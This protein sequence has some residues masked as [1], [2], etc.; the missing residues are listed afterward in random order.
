MCLLALYFSIAQ[1]VPLG[2]SFVLAHTYVQLLH[3][4][5]NVLPHFSARMQ[6]TLSNRVKRVMY[7]VVGDIERRLGEVV[8][9]GDPNC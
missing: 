8:L 5:L 2:V 1:F 6:H 7:Q 4:P 9:G 3:R